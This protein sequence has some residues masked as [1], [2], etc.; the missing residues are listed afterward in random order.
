MSTECPHVPVSRVQCGYCP[1]STSWPV[2]NALTVPQR[3][4]CIARWGVGEPGINISTGGE[5]GSRGACSLPLPAPRHT[6]TRHGPPPHGSRAASVIRRPQLPTL[7]SRH[8][9]KGNY[10]STL[11]AIL[12]ASICNKHCVNRVKYILE[13]KE[14]SGTNE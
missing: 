13:I 2:S 5:P 3:R 8:R 4:K 12:T 7:P 9:F 10:G 11:V 1:P 14:K 6:A